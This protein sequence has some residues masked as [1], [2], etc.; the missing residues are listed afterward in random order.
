MRSI[1]LMAAL[2]VIALMG[3]GCAAAFMA[4]SAPSGAP[5]S[6]KAKYG[7]SACANTAGQVIAA[8]DLTYYLTDD[9][10]YEVEANGRGAKITNRWSDEKGQ[11]FFTYVRTGHG[12]MYFLPSDPAG[13]PTRFIYMKGTYQVTTAGG[14]MRPSGAPSIVCILQPKG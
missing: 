8:P 4:G 3:S 11:Y 2:S 14:V 5:A 13:K 7:I 6:S 10:F 9:A 12:Y 1:R